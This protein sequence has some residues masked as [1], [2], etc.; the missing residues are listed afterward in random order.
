[1][2][3]RTRRNETKRM[4]TKWNEVGLGLAHERMESRDVKWGGSGKQKI[5]V[6][7]RAAKKLT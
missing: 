1:M 3:Q 4:A 2:K 6:K 5:K 7:D